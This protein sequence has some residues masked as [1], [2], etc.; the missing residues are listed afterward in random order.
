[1]RHLLLGLLAC[2]CLAATPPATEA[3]WIWEADTFHLL[4]DPAWTAEVAGFLEAQ[5]VG[6]LYLY[7][8]GY[9]GRNPLQDA[10]DRYHALLADLHRRGFRVEALLGSAPLDSRAYV[11]P[12]R[13]ADARA[14]LQRVLDYN[15]AS[16]APGRFDGVHLDI[17]P[18][19]LAAW[20]DRTREALAVRYLDRSAEWLAMARAADPS[21][22][23]GAAIPFWYDG[24]EV[25]WRGRRRPMNEHV[26]D[27]YDYVAIM[28]Y[29]NRAA[30]PDG[31]VAHAQ[32]ELAYGDLSGHA[33]VV[34]LETGPAEPAKV[35][36]HGLG[37]TALGREM[38]A[39]RARFTPHR[40]FAGFALHHLGTWMALAGWRAPAPRPSRPAGADPR[41]R[42]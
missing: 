7:A 40:S 12:E 1:M 36:F 31:I 17:E 39:A 21:L 5:R 19:T 32:P 26:Q 24:F 3:V 41:S 14:M 37:A 8:D 34:G 27:L 30:G 16:A 29:R 20:N 4:E 35:T 23:M 33:V 11:L 2:A 28:D 42:P 38:A 25:D 18:Y 6:T 15:R 13:S 9:E 10:P 22:R